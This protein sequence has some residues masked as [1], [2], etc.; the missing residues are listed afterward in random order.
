M[1]QHLVQKYDQL[2]EN[3]AELI[4]ISHAD[5]PEIAQQ[6][7]DMLREKGCSAECISSMWEPVTGSH[8]GPGSVALFF[9]G[10]EK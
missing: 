9:W 3:K 5:C 10:T 2:A 1:L 7:L 4:A 8:V 6:L